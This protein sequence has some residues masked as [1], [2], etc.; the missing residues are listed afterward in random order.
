MAVVK[1]DAYGHGMIECVK[2]LKSL[3]NRPD[4]YGVALETEAI[5]LRDSRIIKEPITWGVYFFRK[6]NKFP[7]KVAR[8]IIIVAITKLRIIK[9]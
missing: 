8:L 2:A 6:A 3:K 9:H 4:Y 1:A 7:K 5:E